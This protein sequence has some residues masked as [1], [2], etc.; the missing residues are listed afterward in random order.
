LRLQASALE[1]G[2]SDLDPDAVE[3]IGAVEET[4]TDGDAARVEILGVSVVLPPAA[5]ALSALTVRSDDRRPED[6]LTVDLAGR[7]LII[8]G[9]LGVVS[10]YRDNF[11]LDGEE[12]LVRGDLE[13]Q[14]EL[15]YPFAKHA[16]AFAEI[17]ALNESELYQADGDRETERAIERGE[18]WVYVDGL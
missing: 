5:G 2:S 10:R 6:Q 12:R 15:F 9:E 4:T 13:A 7:P 17:K 8:G 16:A 3:I 11:A 14:L 1:S 18:M